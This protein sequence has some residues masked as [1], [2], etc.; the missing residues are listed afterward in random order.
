MHLIGSFKLTS[1][2]S[3]VCF[4]DF[5]PRLL[6]NKKQNETILYSETVG[7]IP[8]FRINIYSYPVS[9][10]TIQPSSLKLSEIFR[11][12]RF[13][14]LFYITLPHSKQCVLHLNSTKIRVV[15]KIIICL[16]G[17]RIF[18]WANFKDGFGDFSQRRITDLLTG[19]KNDKCSV[20]NSFC[21]IIPR[22]NLKSTFFQL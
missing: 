8:L 19:L 22:I 9:C 1:K 10:R 2:V 4:L 3:R 20:I 12:I 5:S 14:S 6:L 18:N 11:C 7:Y 17:Y 21:L 15:Q 13:S 16:C